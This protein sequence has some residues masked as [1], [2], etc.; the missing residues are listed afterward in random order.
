[1]RIR[2]TLFDAADGGAL[3][4]ARGE[5]S[6]AAMGSI[7]QVFAA[8][9][10]SLVLGPV[11]S[12]TAASGITGTN[13][14]AAW[15]AFQ[16]G[17]SALATWDLEAAQEK[18]REALRL[19]AGY[20]QARLWLAQTQVWEDASVG[21]WR[22]WALRARST[23]ARLTPHDSLLA[24]AL[25]SLAEEDFVAACDRYRALIRRDSSDFAAWFGLG[26]CHAADDAVVPDSRSPSGWRFRSG[27]Q[28]AIHAYRQALR[29][30]PSVYRA[31]QGGAFVRL[32]G[33]FFAENNSHRLGHSLGPDTVYFGAFPALANDTLAFVP[34]PEQAIADGTAP[35]PPSQADAVARNRRA[36]IDITS[37]WV[38]AFPQNATAWVTHAGALELNGQLRGMR[39]SDESALSAVAMA[40]RLTQDSSDQ[41]ALMFREMRLRLKGAEWKSARALAESLLAGPAPEGANAA[42]LL[43][44]A[45]ALLGRVH[46][47]AEQS[48]HA[49]VSATAS[50]ARGGAASVSTD[51][52]EA[53]ARLLVYASVG[54][55][56]VAIDSLSRMLMAT[57]QAYPGERQAALRMQLLDRATGLAWP[58]MPSSGGNYLLD[59]Q[60]LAAA[61]NRAELAT[62]LAALDSLRWAVSPGSIAI[63]P[64]GRC[65]HPAGSP[66]RRPGPASR[67]PCLPPAA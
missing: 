35:L 11:S 63:D 45:A 56:R 37:A 38:D 13:S 6:A 23:S 55:P 51:Q 44:G 14:V 36:L 33:L 21:D 66:A 50:G 54:W 12:A 32:Q 65:W 25:A 62:R 31:F 18:F 39:G 16:S 29:L 28:T 5:V 17:D 9:R 3:R 58:L 30:V 61:G 60:Q 34:W 42:G 27:Y 22:A 19:D 15:K 20:P 26:E 64:A 1:M 2:A 47:A 49:T 41:R 24:D 46:D 7:G 48:A 10:D 8:L 43:A 52:S 53:A 4:E 40:R 67:W 57:V 59:L